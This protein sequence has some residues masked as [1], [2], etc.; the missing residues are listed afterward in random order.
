MK[1]YEIVVVSEY[2]S[3]RKKRKLKR[4]GYRCWKKKAIVGNREVQLWKRTQEVL[5]KPNIL[6]CLRE[7]N[8]F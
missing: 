8:D 3:R 2:T 6:K 1:I 5:D 7:D 4:L